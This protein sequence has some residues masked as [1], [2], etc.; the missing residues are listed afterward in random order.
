MAIVVSHLH[1]SMRG[2]IAGVTYL[3]TP[4]GQIIARQRTVPVDAPTPARTFIKSALI[5]ASAAWQALTV[6][7]KTAW[8]VWAT[9]NGTLSGREEFMAG[10][11]LLYYGINST[12]TGWTSPVDTQTAPVFSGHTAFAFQAVPFV[13]PA[14]TGISV[15]VQNT[16]PREIMAVVEISPMLSNG[17]NYWKGPWDTSL[18]RAKTILTT[19]KEKF[20]FIDLQVGMRYFVRARAFSNSAVAIH[21]GVVISP[22]LIT[23]ATAITNP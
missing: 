13:T 16:S 3:T 1:S 12:P 22:R 6:I 4:S 23:Y 11:T 21:L 15:Q 17:R 10:H 8:N 14:E 2:S 7:Q 5:E 19:V 9:A 20:D 18:N